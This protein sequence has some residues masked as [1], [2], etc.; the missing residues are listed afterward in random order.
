[1]PRKLFNLLESLPSIPEQRLVFLEDAVLSKTAYDDFTA[2]AIQLRFPFATRCG[3]IRFAI[4]TALDRIWHRRQWRRVERTMGRTML[5]FL[6]RGGKREADRRSDRSGEGEEVWNFDDGSDSDVSS[7]GGGGGGG[8][9][10]AD[11]C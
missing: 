9:G 10:E 7:G 5:G 1:M 2:T 4:F 6:R 8:D 3:G 11:A